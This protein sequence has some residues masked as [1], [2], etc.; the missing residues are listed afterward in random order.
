MVAIAEAT[1]IAGAIARAVAAHAAVSRGVCSF[2][3]AALVKCV[4]TCMLERN[5]DNID[6]DVAAALR[7]EVSRIILEAI[8]LN[9]S[10]AYTLSDVQVAIEALEVPVPPANVWNAIHTTIVRRL[11]AARAP[12]VAKHLPKSKKRSRNRGVPGGVP[13]T[14]G[15]PPGVPGT[16]G[17]PPLEAPGTPPLEAP[18]L[19]EVRARISLR[20]KYRYN[21]YQTARRWKSRATKLAK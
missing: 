14:P 11:Q 5:G 19:A 21:N 12:A 16:P 1:A 18:E 9:A 4:Q 2:T 7:R 13:G 8:P 15:T 10:D 20:R 3:R 17:T 6:A